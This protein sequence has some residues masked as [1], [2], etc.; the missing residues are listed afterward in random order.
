MIL[1]FVQLGD[2][3]VD[4]CQIVL[5]NVNLAQEQ[6]LFHVQDDLL[7]LGFIL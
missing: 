2:I 1:L 7:E 4:L 6:L 5:E 3:F